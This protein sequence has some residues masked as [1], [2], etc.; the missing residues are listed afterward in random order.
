LI[1]GGEIRG[2]SITSDTDINVT[3]DAIIGEWLILSP[4]TWDSGIRWGS[5]TGAPY[6]GYDPAGGAITI[7]A[8]GKAIF[9]NQ[10]RIDIPP[11]AV[12]G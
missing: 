4:T 10:Q 6:I 9:A 12:F 3:K 7:N 5:E 1:I 8:R 2:G 11:V